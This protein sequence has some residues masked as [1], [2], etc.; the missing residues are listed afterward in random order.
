MKKPIID[1]KGEWIGRVVDV[2][3]DE[4]NGIL[5]EIIISGSVVDDLWLGRK[6]NACAGQG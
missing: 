5:R 4:N 2:A 1:E 3:F 6:K